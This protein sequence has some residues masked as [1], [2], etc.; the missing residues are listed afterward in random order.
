LENGEW[1]KVAVYENGV[2]KL[3]YEDFIAMGFDVSE[4]APDK[5]QIYGNAEG[6]LPEKMPS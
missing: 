5:I 2:Y 4:I 1:Y 6:L 3:T